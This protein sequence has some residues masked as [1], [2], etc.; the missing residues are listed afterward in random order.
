MASGSGSSNNPNRSLP[1]A[2]PNG[3]HPQILD[4]S[5]YATLKQRIDD[6]RAKLDMMQAQNDSALENYNLV[7]QL[8]RTAELGRRA[9][10]VM[11]AVRGGT[12]TSRDLMHP[13]EYS[14]R[15][16]QFI[17][18]GSGGQ[19]TGMGSAS[20]GARMI[21]PANPMATFPPTQM[22]QAHMPPA[23]VNT[24]ANVYQY[25]P[26]PTYPAQHF[27]AGSMH[28]QNGMGVSAQQQ[29]YSQL[30]HG[31]HI[32]TANPVHTQP[33]EQ[34]ASAY[35]QKY[36][37][38]PQMLSNASTGQ[39]P[40]YSTVQ[41]QPQQNISLPQQPVNANIA[42]SMR[43]QG[44]SQQQINNVYTLSHPS[45]S[46]PQTADAAAS[47][48]IQPSSS[49]VAP[50]DG[51]TSSND[52]NGFYSGSSSSLAGALDDSM[53]PRVSA[54][55]HGS[56]QQ[57][58][59]AAQAITQVGLSN[60]ISVPQPSRDANV[61]NTFQKSFSQTVAPADTQGLPTQSASVKHSTSTRA[62]P[63]F[64][65]QGS[66]TQRPSAQSTS[67]AS[68][69]GSVP[70]ADKNLHKFL[71]IATIMSRQ[72]ERQSSSSSTAAARSPK[73]AQML[74]DLM[75]PT[76]AQSSNPVQ[77][78]NTAVATPPPDPTLPTLAPPRA[79]PPAT[80]SSRYYDPTPFSGPS[81]FF[82]RPQD[83]TRPAQLNGVHYKD[84]FHS[85]ASQN[86]TGSANVSGAA[87]ERIAHEPATQSY[88]P[89][90]H[91][92]LPTSQGK[93]MLNTVTPRLP[94]NQSIPAAHMTPA[95]AD[96]RRL[97]RDILRALG[98]PPKRKASQ[99]LSSDE[100]LKPSPKR[101]ALELPQTISLNPT[102]GEIDSVEEVE[103][104]MTLNEATTSALPDSAMMVVEETP[105]GLPTFDT[106]VAH[107]TSPP[108][109]SVEFGASSTEVADLDMALQPVEFGASNTEIADLDTAFHPV[110]VG[111]SNT[112]V[113]D[114]DTALHPFEESL[115]P[116]FLPSPEPSP[117]SPSQSSASSSNLKFV[118][119]PTPGLQVI[120]EVP[121]LSASL[122][123]KFMRQPTQETKV[124]QADSSLFESLER[125]KITATGDVTEAENISSS[126][127]RRRPCFWQDCAH[128]SNS[129]H[130]LLEHVREHV[131][132]VPK[133]QNKFP[134]QWR[135]CRRRFID[136]D[137]FS[138]HLRNHVRKSIFCAYQ[139]CVSEFTHPLVLYA[140]NQDAHMQNGV[141]TGRLRPSA[142]PFQHV[143]AKRIPPLK[144]MFSYHDVHLPVQMQRISKDRR[145]RIGPWVAKNM[146]GVVNFGTPKL[147]SSR[148]ANKGGRRTENYKREVT[149]A[150]AG[151]WHD[152]YDFLEPPG[153]TYPSYC[154]DLEPLKPVEAIEGGLLLA[155][156]IEG[157]QGPLEVQ[158]L[159]S[160]ADR[161]SVSDA[162]KYMV[163]AERVS[164]R[165][166]DSEIKTEQ[167]DVGLSHATVPDATQEPPVLQPREGVASSPEVNPPPDTDLAQALFLDESQT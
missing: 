102:L 116:L 131:D 165:P 74:A 60:Y 79:L 87:Q 153:T 15:A 128:V 9:Q 97:A 7:Q 125:F 142:A 110:E 42:Q 120:V 59:N 11:E 39:F 158:Y 30:S 161:V 129:A 54:T 121:L 25:A 119:G 106:L 33:V 85:S 107:G 50:T 144:T 21:P 16:A 135:D 127:L 130:A 8:E 38:Q 166:E 117:N 109:P 77:R 111:A 89:Y 2:L 123:R 122:R 167:S 66:D 3:A 46:R 1:V 82:P 83:Q 23:V 28:L 84:A 56:N 101:Q 24:P 32:S 100:E 44:N 115:N 65:G 51:N 96:R 69:N 73:F 58:E 160:L 126:R 155:P 143:P 49:T 26:V 37:I 63:K 164:E 48:F 93:P 75:G 13:G 81:K 31:H 134:C 18:S 133:E 163:K 105:P 19:S 141:E 53:Y 40:Y 47:Q 149:T 90:A 10:Q 41:A 67:T 139:G 43:Y 72:G 113:T 22:T 114:L 71:Q 103:N 147:K 108:N 36:G 148:Q 124:P 70:D 137:A 157:P 152:K 156:D 20:T 34:L 12:M 150:I 86:G 78:T 145:A 112:E 52:I 68:R 159:T 4:P 99:S 76:N 14:R 64:N 92:L 154:E 132:S 6:A 17:S 140:H 35:A 151:D 45:S 91:R 118:R 94:Q 80:S 104:S 61:L 95:N 29:S 88:V 146:F 5:Q 162:Q 57:D 136:S 138:K 55:S 98:A 27:P 62:I